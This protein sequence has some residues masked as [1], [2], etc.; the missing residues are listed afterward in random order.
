MLRVNSQVRIL[1]ILCVKQTRAWVLVCYSHE[2]SLTP[3]Q[4]ANRGQTRR[5]GAT[6]MV[7]I[8]A[9]HNLDV[10]VLDVF[11]QLLLLVADVTDI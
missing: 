2:L 3:L 4:R 5:K 11:D 1:T 7:T 9:H 6:R 8:R 10:V